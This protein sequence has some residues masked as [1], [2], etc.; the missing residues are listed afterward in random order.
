Q[1]MDK[2]L[3]MAEGTRS[4]GRTYSTKGVSAASSSDN[5]KLRQ[6]ISELKRIVS[7]LS[8]PGGQQQQVKACGICRDMSHHTDQCPELQEPNATDVHVMGAYGPPRPRLTDKNRTSKGGGINHNNSI[9]HLR[10]KS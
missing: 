3:D 8:K 2:L 1:A 6:E 9:L 4:F 7:S 5:L 10:P